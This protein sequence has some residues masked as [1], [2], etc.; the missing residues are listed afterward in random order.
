[1][2]GRRSSR[3][4]SWSS[5]GGRSSRRR[6]RINRRV[7]SSKRRSM[8]SRRS[9]S[10]YQSRGSPGTRNTA[11]SKYSLAVGHTWGGGIGQGGAEVGATL[12]VDSKAGV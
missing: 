9:K 12:G 1:M 10:S 6:G 3:R 8:S 7:R 2:R 11:C 5:R 4:G